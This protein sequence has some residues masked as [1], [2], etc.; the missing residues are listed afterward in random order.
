[1][2]HPF[3]RILFICALLFVPAFLLS[4]G[5]SVRA[6]GNAAGGTGIFKLEDGLYHYL[7][8]GVPQDDFTGLYKSTVNT[9]T[10][11]VKNGIWKSSVNGLVKRPA[12]GKWVYVRNGYFRSSFTGVYTSSQGK[13]YFLIKGVWEKN[14]T[15]LVKRSSD[16]QY[17]YVIKGVLQSSF[18]GLYENP[19]NDHI[20]Y[21]R[22]GVWQ[23]SATTLVKRTDDGKWV[24]IR[25]GYFRSGFTG[26][27]TSSQG[28]DYFLI[29]GVWEK[30]FSGLVKRSSDKQYVYVKKGVL[31]SSFTGLYLSSEGKTRYIQNGVWNKAFTGIF[32]DGDGARYYIR[33]G[34]WNKT[35][36]GR[37][38]YNKCLYDVADGKVVSFRK[39]TALAHRKV[40]LI[41]ID[42]MR[43][44]GFQQCGN[45]YVSDI[46]Q[47]GRYTLSGQ[48]VYPTWTFPVHYSVFHGISPERHGI[49]ENYYRK[50]REYVNGLM[51]HLKANGKTTAMFY[52]W[53]TIRQVAGSSAVDY[54]EYYDAAAATGADR[55]LT[56]QAIVCL[57]EDKP[58][59]LFLYL[60]DT[61]DRGGH[62]YGWMSKKYLSVLSKAIDCVKMIREAAGEEYTVLI[63]TDHG[64]H[65]KSHGTDL[66]ED[67]T[68]PFFALGPDF[69]G[70]SLFSG[71]T[72]LD[73][74][75]TVS[76]LMGLAP[77]P[78]WEGQ[79]L[80]R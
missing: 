72:V 56:Q 79:S 52:G 35:Y 77:D 8:D 76:E 49:T 61:D 62:A 73:I 80:L 47:Q 22:N 3:R 67:M 74:A 55:Y 58:D 68:I 21:N 12:D 32:K 27:Y 2:K 11:Y 42:G 65:G 71:F 44:D 78:G 20:C 7:I 29:K 28:K 36:E 54:A 34:L 37:I 19:A 24:Y 17:V 25:N 10:Y 64:G 63:M 53:E 57:Q 9:H 38:T 59:F 31:Q 69:E 1:M 16:K 66:P 48:S 39:Y 4:A 51:E 40:I 14:F 30:N 18:T 6:A 15:G 26:V 43:P 23:S 75:P 50:P 33:N 45:P 60:V 41:S 13:E 5:H 70:G 46:L